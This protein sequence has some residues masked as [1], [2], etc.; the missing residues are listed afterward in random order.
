MTTDLTYTIHASKT[1][2]KIHRLLDHQLRPTCRLL[3]DAIETA[4]ELPPSERHFQLIQ[5]LAQQCA[6]DLELIQREAF[7][8]TLW[9]TTKTTA[10]ELP[11]DS[12]GGTL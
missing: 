3:A 2:E 1:L 10:A 11:H 9:T 8:A 6:V 12:E 4:N 5:Y 7:Q